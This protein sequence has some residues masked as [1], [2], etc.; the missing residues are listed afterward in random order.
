MIRWLLFSRAQGMMIKG[1][2]IIVKIVRIV[3]IVR[4]MIA[5]SIYIYIEMVYYLILC[6]FNSYFLKLVMR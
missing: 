6:S 4:M 2:V 1:I 3:R 5:I